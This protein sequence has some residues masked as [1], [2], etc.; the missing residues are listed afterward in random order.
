M[1]VHDAYRRRREAIYGA[2][3]QT[4]AKE[5]TRDL[6][7]GLLRILVLAAVVGVSFWFASAP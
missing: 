6:A 3:R 2:L 5:A 4:S 1:A 7:R